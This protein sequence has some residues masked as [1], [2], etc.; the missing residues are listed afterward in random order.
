VILLQSD[1]D[2]FETNLHRCMD[3]M[4]E[5]VGVDRVC[6]WKNSTID[7]ELY[8]TKLYEQ[9]CGEALQPPIPMVDIPYTKM[10]GWKETL[11]RGDCVVGLA[12]DMN[13]VVQARLKE[14]KVIAICVI[15]IF[16]RDQFWGFI[17]YDNYREERVYSENEQS[18]LRSGGM[19]IANAI[20][21]ND[22]TLSLRSSAEQLEVALKDAQAANRAKSSF[23]A[24]MSH[25]MRTPLNAVIGLCGLKL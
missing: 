21:R 20:L 16:A 22:M 24:H 4:A 14:E 7:G 13:S 17:G 9:W 12:T 25:E 6:I 15:P 18:I 1:A 5:A 19:L 2:A 23:L 3:M 10:L 8:Y 11:S